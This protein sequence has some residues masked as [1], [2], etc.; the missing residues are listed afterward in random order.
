[1]TLKVLFRSKEHVINF[2]SD[3][4]KAKDILKHFD[5]SPEYAFVVVDGKVVSED[6][7][8]K[9]D[10]KIKVVSAISGG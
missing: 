7:N 9:S 5:L 8:L 10:S 4:V 6:E 3:I 1:M 2:P